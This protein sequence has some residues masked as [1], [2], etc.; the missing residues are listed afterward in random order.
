MSTV[1][2]QTVLSVLPFL[3]T[4]LHVPAALIP[5]LV[6]GIQEA[7]QLPGVKGPEKKAH[8][9]E[10]VDLAIQGINAAKHKVV[11][12]AAKVTPVIDHAI[13]VGIAVANLATRH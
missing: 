9:L 7:E 11:I 1:W 12:D 13:D 4:I 5:A 3:F 8:V 6:H 10:L 2:V